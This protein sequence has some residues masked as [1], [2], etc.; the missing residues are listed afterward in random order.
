MGKVY[1]KSYQITFYK[2]EFIQ[3]NSILENEEIR[4]KIADFLL[5]YVS[6][7]AFYK[8][9]LVAEK[10]SNGKKPTMKERKRLS[11]KVQDVKRVFDCYGI[12]YDADLIER[13]FGSND[14]NYTDCSI[15]KLRDR[16]VHNVNDNVLRAVLERYDTITS[17]L[18]GFVS[19]FSR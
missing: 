13:V 10:E 14:K 11:V 7:E 19:L 5:K 6:V 4:N 16:L 8:K 15:K 17:D 1:E 9:L 18:D 3:F 2:S 12:V